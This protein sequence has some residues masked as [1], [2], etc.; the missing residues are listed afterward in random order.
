MS[1]LRTFEADVTTRW[2]DAHRTVLE[3]SEWKQD[4]S[5][6]SMETAD[7]ITVFE[8]YIR[9]IER[10][11]GERRKKE[12]NE[13]VRA[14]RKRR[15]AFR[16]LMEEGRE[17]GWIR[18]GVAWPDV[19]QRIKDDQRFTSMLGQRGSTPLDL[20]FDAVDACEQRVEART[21][22][23]TELIKKAEAQWKGVPDDAEWDHFL[24]QVQA[25]LAA[26]DRS[27]RWASA[28]RDDVELRQVFDQLREES[29]RAKREA[30][31]RHE[32]KVRH[33]I[34][35]ARYGLKK[36]L[37]DTLM[38][39]AEQ[40]ASYE[41]V[42]DRIEALG[43]REWK[44]IDVELGEEGGEREE[45][46]RTTWEKF[47]RRQKEK[48]EERAAAA[49]AASSSRKRKSDASTSLLGAGGEDE[50][51]SRRREDRDLRRRGSAEPGRGGGG[52]GEEREKRRSGRDEDSVMEPAPSSSSSARAG[53][54][55]TKRS[56][57]EEASPPVS[58][59]RRA[60]VS[61]SAADDGDKEEGEV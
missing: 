36:D 11:E 41:S 6:S 61:Q 55:G 38:R 51:R 53:S 49:A 59:S 20:F 21:A 5:L 35:D 31:R 16:A 7:M 24:G 29:A 8:E 37:N 57:R 30:K 33:L 9:S 60:M 25:G 44:A 19:Y 28:A 12:D 10:E 39:E 18:A 17:Q 3:S 4:A 23:V 48:T 34:D 15:V 22:A 2:R 50:K 58:S 45:V 14:E 40:G 13:R 1:L 42:K 52:G 43:I 56:R 27:E 26:T 46:K 47:C 54:P 32:R